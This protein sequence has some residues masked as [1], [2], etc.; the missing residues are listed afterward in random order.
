MGDRAFPVAGSRLWNT[1]PH[2]VTSAPTL[3]V[4]CNRVKAHPFKL[5]FSFNQT[6]IFPGFPQWLSS[7]S[8]TLDHYK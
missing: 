8:E 3:P 5:S 2:D 7:F 4:F 1:L 6:V